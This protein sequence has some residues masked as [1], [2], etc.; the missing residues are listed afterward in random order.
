MGG[1]TLNYLDMLDKLV[2]IDANG[3]KN[4]DNIPD[5]PPIKTLWKARYM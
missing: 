5:W 3:I 2:Y 1:N 4:E